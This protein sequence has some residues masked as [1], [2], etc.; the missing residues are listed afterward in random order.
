[1]RF[2]LKAL[3]TSRTCLEHFHETQRRP[4][5][6][7]NRRQSRL[8][9]LRCMGLFGVTLQTVKSLSLVRNL[10]CPLTQAVDEVVGQGGVYIEFFQFPTR[11]LGESGV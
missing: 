5:P 10:K 9:P 3:S 4:S 7:G 1:M 8:L 11:V 6:G 2:S